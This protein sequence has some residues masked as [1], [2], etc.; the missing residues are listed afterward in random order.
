MVT[1]LIYKGDESCVVG[2]LTDI[3]ISILALL[4][5]MNG[6]QDAVQCPLGKQKLARILGN[7]SM[8]ATHHHTQPIVKN[9]PSVQFYYCSETDQLDSTR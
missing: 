5:T 4:N 9:K 6:I 3:L 1:S 8:M 2:K 7:F